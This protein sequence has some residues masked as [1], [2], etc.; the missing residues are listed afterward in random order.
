MLLNHCDDNAYFAHFEDLCGQ[1]RISCS[2]IVLY[3]ILQVMFI[4]LVVQHFIAYF[5]AEKLGENDEYYEDASASNDAHDKEINETNS[6]QNTFTDRIV[7]GKVT[8]FKEP[9]IIRRL[10]KINYYYCYFYYMF[11]ISILI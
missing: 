1:G 7:K 10:F 5:F 8:I 2:K 11:L 6:I 9:K 3:S 4:V